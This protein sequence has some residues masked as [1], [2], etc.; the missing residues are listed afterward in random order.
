MNDPTAGARRRR[1]PR[2]RAGAPPD[3]KVDSNYEVYEELVRRRMVDVV[4]H[5]PASQRNP[6]RLGVTA[7][8]GA[9]VERCHTEK[10]LAPQ[11]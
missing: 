11:R 6:E 8:G 1:G 2:G 3:G 4:A 5:L 9:R 10:R 7:R